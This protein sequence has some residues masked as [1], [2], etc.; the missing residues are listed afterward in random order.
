M[1]AT[2]GPDRD[3]VLPLKY[4]ASPSRKKGSIKFDGLELNL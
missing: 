3:T 4:T 1:S 2:R